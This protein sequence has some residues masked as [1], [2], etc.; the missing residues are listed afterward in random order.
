MKKQ[1]NGGR[2]FKLNF[3]AY[4]N[5]LFVE[6]T[7][8][9]T[10]K[11]RFLLAIDKEED[12]SKLDWCSFVLEY[13]KRT[14]QVIWFFSNNYMQ[15]LYNH[16]F[17]SRH[18]IF[19]EV[20]KLPVI[21]YITSGMIDDMEEYLYNNGPL[22]VEDCDEVDKDEE[23]HDN[24]QDQQYVTA[25]D[26][27]E[28]DH[29]N[30]ETPTT[31][32]K[33]VNQ[34]T[35]MVFTDL[36]GGNI[37]LHEAAAVQENLTA[38]DT[39]DQPRTDTDDYSIPPVDTTQ[40]YTR[41]NLAGEDSI[42]E[43]YIPSPT[44]WFEGWNPSEHTSDLNLEEMGIGTQTQKELDYCNTPLQLTGVIYDHAAWEASNK[45]KKLLLKTMDKNINKYISLVT[46]MNNLIK[47]LKEKCFWNLEIM[48]MCK[49]WDDVVKNTVP[50]RTDQVSSGGEE[51]IQNKVGED[52][53]TIEELGGDGDA[54]VEHKNTGKNKR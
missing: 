5:T 43:G 54:T 3:L 30:E 8:S 32:F 53:D 48:R 36:F 51:A 35:S 29:Q 20:V 26:I 11:Q 31:P 17:N 9:T 42:D 50:M 7:K 33:I 18:K 46:E 49:R 47:D 13:L 23:T 15:L 1:T 38:F 39:L 34:Q 27:N 41:R 19:D 10:V 52:G 24:R 6:V 12:I 22:N 21:K 37:P 25:S 16:Y 45:T 14:R 44:D 2:L 28:D 40:V 4:W